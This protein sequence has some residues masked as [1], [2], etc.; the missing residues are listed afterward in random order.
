MKKNYILSISLLL[1]SGVSEAQWSFS[2]TNIYNSNTGNVGVGS[3]TPTTLFEAA[4]NM[5]E[6]TITVRNLGG[7]GGATY[8][9]ADNIS[10]ANWKFKVTSTGGFKIRDHAYALDVF[11]IESNSAANALYINSAGNIG[12]STATP[13]AKL[14]IA[15][16]NNW[17]LVDGEGDVRIGN[18]LFRLKLGVALEGGGAGAAGIMQYG[19]AGGY[20]VLKLGSQGNYLLF[21][22]G[23]SQRVGIGTDSPTAKLDIQ[24]T[25]RVADGTQGAGKVLTSDASG[26]ASWANA[27]THFIGESYGGGKVFYVYDNGQHGLIAATSDQS[28]GIQWSNDLYRYT[29]TTGDGLGAGAMNTALI[30]AAQMGDNQAGNFA[31]KVCADYSVTMNEIAY[32][33]WY[34]PSKYESDLLYLQ[35]DIVG[36][37]SDADYWTSTE[38]SFA[39]SFAKHKY[40]GNGAQTF[41]SDVK[42]H[43]YRVRAIRAF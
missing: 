25:L 17:N 2:G 7:A 10:G 33:D 18:G 36:G 29:G 22:N 3:N 9:M 16:G 21:I 14:D 27:S 37:F 12:I 28:A 35:K 34:L 8:S 15:G 38:E 23:G 11:T 24:G 5:T 31:A 26:V 19:M 13:A 20:N 42:Y 32:G 41:P 43:S 4:K 1:I 40:F 6:P 30:I 39:N